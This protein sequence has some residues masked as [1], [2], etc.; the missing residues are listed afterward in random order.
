MMMMMMDMDDGDDMD[1]D[2]DDD[3]DDM[4]DVDDGDDMD[5]V[6]VVDDGDVDCVLVSNMCLFIWLDL[7]GACCGGYLKSS[8]RMGGQQLDHKVSQR[9]IMIHLN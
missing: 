7:P 3:G 6:D 4:D 1:D 9:F 8:T 5:D 2:D